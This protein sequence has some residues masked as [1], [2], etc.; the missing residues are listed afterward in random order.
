MRELWDLFWSFTR[1]G[2]FTFGGGYAMLPLMQREIVELKQWATDEQM[3]DYYAVAQCIPGII[4]INT[5]T[6]VGYDRR[7]PAGAVAATLGM[8]FPSIVIIT[9]IASFVHVFEETPLL[10][11]AFA[12]VRIAVTA[13]IIGAV[14][15]M[16]R[17]S[18]VNSWGALLF[19]TALL[20]I[21]FLKLSPIIVI[22]AAAAVG[23]WLSGSW[24]RFRSHVDGNN[25][26]REDTL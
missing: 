22:L 25:E 12:G 11:H 17:S 13:L 24:R 8:V 2:T 5:A 6:F 23:I 19:F 18:V 26:T 7:G 1:I 4:A 14:V 3:V 10:Q 21:F 9:L 20:L 15:N 16:W